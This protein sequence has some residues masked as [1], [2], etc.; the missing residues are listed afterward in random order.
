M[1]HCD[2]LVIMLDSE[3]DI[4]QIG[5]DLSIRRQLKLIYCFLELVLL[6]LR[7]SLSDDVNSG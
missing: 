3:E 6:K 5:E 4:I 1:D 7:S 2:Y